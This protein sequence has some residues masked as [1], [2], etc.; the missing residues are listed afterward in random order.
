MDDNPYFNTV[1]DEQKYSTGRQKI[2]NYFEFPIYNMR[3][4]FKLS[5]T[6][7]TQQK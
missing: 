7:N 2:T 1:P 5:S 6:K 4:I 3:K